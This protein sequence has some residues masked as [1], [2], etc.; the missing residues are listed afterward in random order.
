MPAFLMI[1]LVVKEPEEYKEYIAAVPAIAAQYGG[2]YIARAASS[3]AI[4]IY[5]GD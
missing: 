4:E 5:E 3:E 2:I 1:D